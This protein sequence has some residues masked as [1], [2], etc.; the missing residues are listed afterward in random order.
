MNTEDATRMRRPRMKSYST[1]GLQQSTKAHGAA[2]TLTKHQSPRATPKGHGHDDNS[3]LLHK[4]P[5]AKKRHVRQE[6]ETL[7]SRDPTAGP[8]SELA[9]DGEQAD[10]EMRD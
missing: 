9:E 8:P 1:N 4:G 5:P 7:A 10:D 3:R 2:G 6:G